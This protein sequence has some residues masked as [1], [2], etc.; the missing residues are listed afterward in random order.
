MPKG[1]NF[2][3]ADIRSN[4]ISNFFKDVDVVFHLAAKNCIPDCQADPKETF[5]INVHGSINVFQIARKYK[6]KKIVFADSS[7]VYEGE[8]EFPSKENKTKPISYYALSKQ[9]ITNFLSKFANESNIDIIALRYFNVYG[10]NQDYRRTIPPLMSAFIIK[11]MQNKRPIIYGNGSKRRDFI[12]VDDINSFHNL[13]I[14]KKMKRK[15][16]VYNLGSGKNY[17]VNDIFEI[18]KDLMKS[19]IKPTFKKNL[20]GE[21]KITKANISKAKK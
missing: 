2:H 6:V 21:A 12:H 8:K 9:T 11:I 4:K 15:F 14:Q 19:N 10:I 18:I 17:S 7:A 5:D 3:K 1:V 20:E 13:I 16:E